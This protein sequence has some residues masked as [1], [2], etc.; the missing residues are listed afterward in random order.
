MYDTPVDII[1][2]GIK[3]IGW[4][5]V[6]ALASG[7]VTGALALGWKIHEYAMRWT[8]VEGYI[9]KVSTNDV[10]HIFHTLINVDKNIAK[11]SGGDKVDFTELN[12]QIA[13]DKALV[14]K[15]KL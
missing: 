13:T 3:S 10:P 8:I 1:A 11:M 4:G 9:A 2:N 5:T 14:D 6:A 7:A 15:E 12:V